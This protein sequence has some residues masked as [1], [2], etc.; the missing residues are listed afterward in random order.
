[1]IQD[2][3]KWDEKLKI[4]TVGRDDS[5]EDEH[6]F[7]YEPTPYCVLER[8]ADSGFLSKDNVLVDYGSGKGRVD[9]F[10][11]WKLGCKTIGIEFDSNVYQLSMEN[12]KKGLSTD[13]VNFLL[14]NAEEYEIDKDA[15]SFYFFNPFSIKILQ[16]VLSKIKMSWYENPRKMQFF[17]YYPSNEYIGSLMMCDELE[18]VDEIDCMDLFEGNDIRERILIF[19]LDEI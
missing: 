15:D 8:M 11:S 19:K 2:E 16:T 6:H 10:L 18:F 7:P 14:I 13:K 4:N 1:M 3:N 12:K 5:K 17:F 9:L